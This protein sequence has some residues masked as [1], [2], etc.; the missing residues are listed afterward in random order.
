MLLPRR[1]CGSGS[2]AR[3]YA[4]PALRAEGAPTGHSSAGLARV[5]RDKIGPMAGP[6]TIHIK[7]NSSGGWA[8][9]NGTGRATGV[10]STQAEA[11]KAAQAI[12]RDVGGQLLVHTPSGQLKK[13][14]TLGRTAMGK[15]N[16]V[17]GVS[18]SPAGKTAFKTFDRDD[19]TPAQRRTALRK[20]V[21]K[22]T[23]APKQASSRASGAATKG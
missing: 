8:V 7:P 5:G 14:F 23:G 10:Y 17:E 6:K 3:L 13:S 4:S 19:L 18:L 16:A 1:L 11:V 15:L 21:T 9:R 12:V 22:L 20:D 2:T